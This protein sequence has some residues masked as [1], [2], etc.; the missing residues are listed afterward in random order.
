MKLRMQRAPACI[1]LCLSLYESR[2][3]PQISWTKL[4]GDLPS[5]RTSLLNY[6]KTLLIE[7]VSASDAGDYRCTA[8]NQLGSVHH[9]IHVTVK[10]VHDEIHSILSDAASPPHLMIDLVTD[11]NRAVD[12]V[13][14]CPACFCTLC[15]LQLLR[16]GSAALRGTSS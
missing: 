1:T 9:T 8:K 15:V 3:T 12:L 10:G 13:I 6:N 5:K 2:P 11:A 14:N 16:I 7:N 4:S